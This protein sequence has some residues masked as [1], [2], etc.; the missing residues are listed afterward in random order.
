MTSV[1]IGHRKARTRIEENSI[2]YRSQ[3][4]FCESILFVVVVVFA[5]VDFDDGSRVS[6][7]YGGRLVG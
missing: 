2:R 5:A 1:R 4:M 3:R 6:G 7:G